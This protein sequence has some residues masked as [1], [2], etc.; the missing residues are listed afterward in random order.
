MCWLAVHTA[1]RLV[2]AGQFADVQLYVNLRGFDPEH[3]VAE[4]S[5]VLDA[6]LRHLGVPGRQIPDSLE[7]RAAMFRDRL[8]GLNALILLDNAADEDQVRELIPSGP[9]CLVLITSRRSLTGLAAATLC[10][11]DVFS[12]SEA[13]ELLARIAGTDRVAAEPEAAEQIAAACG[14]LPLAVS[15]AA[16]RLRARPAWR[17]ANLVDRIQAG[18]VDAVSPRDLSLRR[19]FDLSYQGLAEPEQRLY[20]LLSLHPGREVSAPAAA[21][22]ADIS[23]IEAVTMLERLQD[24]HLLQQKNFGRYELHDLLRAFAATLAADDPDDLRRSAIAR[25]TSWY[26]FTADSTNPLL[27]LKI[28]QAGATCVYG[29]TPL[30]FDNRDDA[31]AWF[32]LEYPALMASVETAAAHGMHETA[33]MLAVSMQGFFLLRH[34]LADW[35][36][37][38][39]TA[40]ASARQLDD[41][42]GQDRVLTGLGRVY[43]TVE[44]LAD[45]ESCHRQVVDLARQGRLADS[46]R[47]EA[48]GLNN[49]ATVYNDQGRHPEAL[50][51]LKLALTSCRN[52]QNKHLE[53]Y[54]LGNTGVALQRL[55]KPDEAV[56]T[57]RESIAVHQGTGNRHSEMIMWNNLGDALRHIGDLKAALEAFR[58][59]LRLGTE[60]GDGAFEGTAH[61]N[62]GDVLA[63]TGRADEACQAWTQAHAIFERIGHKRAADTQVRLAASTPA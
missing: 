35:V 52:Q 29:L 60:I 63:A 58:H 40:L 9:G 48:T 57:Y 25:V 42:Q 62:I 38:Y 6:F 39:E 32:D 45:A 14:H 54:V 8:H 30:V 11:L 24:E 19:V 10:Q 23:V 41:A 55:G 33:W 53:G 61:M 37:T 28:T 50:D 2:R 7:E 36:Q 34:R 49:L 16:T 5:G 21:A 22:I 17:L 44:R 43:R 20:R 3:A 12:T 4:A 26:L 18:G 46:V 27:D 15:L 51:I 1:H 13:V 31:L 47:R 59:S 56:Q